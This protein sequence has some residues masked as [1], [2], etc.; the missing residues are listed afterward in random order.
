MR[1]VGGHVSAAGGIE[2]AIERGAAIGG[3]CVQ[4]FSGS[5]R[6]WARPDI[7]KFDSK[8]IAAKC[9]PG[10]APIGILTTNGISS[11]SPFLI[12]T[13]SITFT[14]DAKPSLLGEKLGVPDSPC[15]SKFSTEV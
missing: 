14:H 11:L 5:P 13:L 10:S 6:V 9:P 4:V 2:L 8:K 12:S 7:N 15:A 3:N 1:Q